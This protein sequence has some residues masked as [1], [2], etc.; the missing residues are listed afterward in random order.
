MKKVKEIKE[1]NEGMLREISKEGRINI[2]NKV[3]KEK[4]ERK[5]ERCVK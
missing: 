4:K 3:K 1:K 5:K 2:G